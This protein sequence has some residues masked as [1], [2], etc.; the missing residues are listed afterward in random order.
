M[1]LRNPNPNRQ[2]LGIVAMG[3]ALVIAAFL[4]AVIGLAWQSA[5]GLA[6]DPDDEVLTG[7]AAPD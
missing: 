3:T 6:G 4:G 2:P 7:E 5:E 1:A